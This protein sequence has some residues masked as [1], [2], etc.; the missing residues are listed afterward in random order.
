MAQIL[1]DLRYALRQCRKA[2]GFAL[3]TVLTL[4]L[5]IGATT[6][7]FSV[8]DGVLL[9]PLAYRESNQLVA[10][11]ER[12]PYL[13]KLVPYIGPNPRHALLW[14]QSQTAFSD[15]SIVNEGTTGVALAG[16]HP[17]YVGRVVAEPNLLSLLGTQPTLGRDFRPDEGA[18]GSNDRVLIS[19]SLWHDL[20][21]ASPDVLGKTL[22]VGGVP[23]TVIGVLPNGFYFPRGNELTASPAPQ[24]TP[25]VDVLVPNQITPA[26]FGWNGDYGNFAVLGRLRPGITPAAAQAQLNGITSAM[27]HGAP[28]GQFEPGTR[29]TPTTLV[30]PMKQVIVGRA[31]TGLFVLL[32]AVV[33]VL[34]IACINLANAQLARILARNREAALRTALGASPWSL[35]RASVLESL[36][37]ALLG[38]GL[39][40]LL[41]RAAIQRSSAFIHVAIPRAANI[42]IDPVVLAV[43]L[44]CTFAATVLF[45]ALP[46]LSYFRVRPQAALAGTGRSAGSTGATTLRRLLIGAQVLACTALLLV[47]SLFARNLLHLFTQD[48]GFS[49]GGT[50]V[51]DIRLQGKSFTDPVIASLHDAVLDRLRTLPGVTSAA[52]V[53]SILASGQSWV[54]GVNPVGVEKQQASLAQYRWVSPDYFTTVRQRIVAGRALDARD[55][56]PVPVDTD[57]GNNAPLNPNAPPTAAVLSQSTAAAIWPNQDPLGRLFLRDIHRYRVVGIAAD[58]RTNSPHEQPES[59]VFLPYWD[60]PPARAFYLVH[61]TGDP[62]LL[63]PAVRQAIWSYNPSITIADVRPLDTIFADALAPERLQ[64]MLLAA[65]GIAA[66]LLALLGIYATLNYSIGRRTQEIGIRMAL[67]ASRE[68]VYL[69]TLREVATPIAAGLVAGWLVSLAVIRIAR[70]LLESTS[71]ANFSSIAAVFGILLATTACATY[72]PCRRAS[73][74][75]PMDALRT[76]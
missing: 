23:M 74:L 2:P 60:N 36:V 5:G 50:V 10:V 26:N 18:K 63:A 17:R 51:A 71:S 44:A 53:S 40:L 43:S 61:G 3:T 7:I 14:R 42:A 9:Q 21:A 72:F 75:Q 55:R 34:L 62:A 52:L 1:K 66:L 38:D 46:A 30:Q 58:A 41:A 68:N 19:W 54:D 11:W 6:A 57:A 22:Q 35:V 67:G 45:G 37:L 39:G 56:V 59:M 69:L 33:S 76:E 32:A 31:R 13:E 47:T 8:V 12:V 64:T 28:A 4:A 20:F 29:G 65:F 49:T 25:A 48:Q 27:V 24:Q 70:S 15:L 73:R 16:D